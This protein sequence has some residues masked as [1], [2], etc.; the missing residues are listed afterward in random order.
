MQ[1]ALAR[2]LRF[3]SLTLCLRQHFGSRYCG[4]GIPRFGQSG[5]RE[6]F[7]TSTA[8]GQTH[9]PKSANQTPE[10]QTKTGNPKE[11][12]TTPQNAKPKQEPQRKLHNAPKHQTLNPK[13]RRKP[14]QPPPSA[15]GLLHLPGGIRLAG[16]VDLGKD[17]PQKGTTMEPM[18]IGPIFPGFRRPWGQGV[19]SLELW[20]SGVVSFRAW[21]LQG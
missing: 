14:P 8:N 17:V 7:S 4:L 3:G 15:V 19:W 12:S 6:S 13:P 21:G 11:N 16:D 9:K 10:H 2:M 18:G 20:G 1:S 5:A